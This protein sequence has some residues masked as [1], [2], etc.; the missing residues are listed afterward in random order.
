VAAIDSLISING[1]GFV[2]QVHVTSAL[3]PQIDGDIPFI[4]NT[5][6]II[7]NDGLSEVFPADA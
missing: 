2:H 7:G 3:T 1:R 5:F 4:E 6:S